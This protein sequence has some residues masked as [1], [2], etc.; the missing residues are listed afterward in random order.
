MV[1][2]YQVL[3]H[4]S[5]IFKDWDLVITFDEPVIKIDAWRDV[6]FK[7]I[8]NMVGAMGPSTYLLLTMDQDMHRACKDFKRSVGCI[9]WDASASQVGST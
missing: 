8:E 2:S 5:N 9:R 4:V 6:V 3:C 1:S 7:W